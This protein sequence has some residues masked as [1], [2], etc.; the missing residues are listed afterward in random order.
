MGDPWFG[1]RVPEKQRHSTVRAE[2]EVREGRRD[3]ESATD[4]E[5]TSHHRGGSDSAKRG[6]LCS[7]QAWGA[8]QE[9]EGGQGLRFSRRRAESGGHGGGGIAWQGTP[10]HQ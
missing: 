4:P 5:G 2:C 1:V 7:G 3:E 6:P 8:E 10:C 9:E